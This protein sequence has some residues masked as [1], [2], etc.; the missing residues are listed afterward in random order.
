MFSE[1]GIYKELTQIAADMTE[2]RQN[3]AVLKSDVADLKLVAGYCWCSHCRPPIFQ[4]LRG[5][6]SLQDYSCINTALC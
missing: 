4:A 2:L 3:V 6:I 1:D 5:Y